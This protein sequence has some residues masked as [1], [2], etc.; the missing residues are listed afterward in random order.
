VLI[1]IALMTGLGIAF[2]VPPLAKSSPHDSNKPSDVALYW[3]EVNR[4]RDGEG[5]YQAAA[6]ELTARGYATRSD[7]NWRTPL[8]MWAL[9]KP[10]T[11][12]LGK[13]LLNVMALALM[14]LAFKALTLEEGNASRRPSAC[15]L[16][17]SGPL[18]QAI[19]DNV[20]VVPVLWSG[21]LI[22]LSV[23]AYG[24]NRPRW[25]VALGLAAIF[26]RELALPYCLV[27]A[28]IAWWQGRRSELAAWTLGLLA[29]LA[30]FGLHWWHV[31]E[32]IAYDAKAHREGWIQFGGIEFVI[33]TAQMNVYLLLLPKWVTAIYLAAAL[34][35]L[36]G[37]NTPL[38]MRIALTVSVFVAAFAVVGH[39]FNQYWGS[40]MTPLL[41]FGVVRFPISMR[42][43]ARAAAYRCSAM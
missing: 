13:V 42:D 21:V 22:A 35:G 3:A 19:V 30:F 34:V 2:T 20:F 23:C 27:C 18:L 24:V 32:R 10:P 7:F 8:P 43:L 41:C 28:A 11:P 37:W 39:S 14:I 16:L 25:G 29:W 38:G 12:L 5:Y 15:V 6:T 17:L 36:A 40:L 4:I 9:G 33:S 26:F 1:A 31:S